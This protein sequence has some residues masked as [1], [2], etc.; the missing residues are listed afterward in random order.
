MSVFN[1]SITL[2]TQSTQF[3]CRIYSFFSIS[4][5]S[6][7]LWLINSTLSLLLKL[8]LCERMLTASSCNTGESP[9]NCLPTYRRLSHTARSN[10]SQFFIVNRNLV[11]AKCWCVLVFTYWERLFVRFS[12]LWYWLGIVQVR[13]AQTS[14]DPGSAK[15]LVSTEPCQ[16]N[17]SWRGIGRSR[18]GQSVWLDSMFP[19]LLLSLF[20]ES[21]L[22]RIWYHNA[23]IQI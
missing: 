19:L 2:T 3:I 18:L 12:C 10:S 11:I 6:K 15:S 7:V 4:Q 22:L 5:I 13:H 1:I 9:N 17:V 23:W 16:T 21:S 20:D 8:Q 14:R